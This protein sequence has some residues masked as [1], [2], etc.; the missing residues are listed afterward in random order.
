M[1]EKGEKEEVEREGRDRRRSRNWGEAETA[2]REGGRQKK[3]EQRQ[4][5]R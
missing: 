5:E 1:G 3:G 4:K 2:F